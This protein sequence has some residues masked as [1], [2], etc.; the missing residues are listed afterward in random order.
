MSDSIATQ[1]IGHDLSGLTLV[2]PDQ[3][4]EEAFCSSAISPGLQEHV[5]YLA[6][7]VY[8]PPQ[9]MLLTIDLDEHF[10]DEKGITVAP[11]FSLQ[12]A[13]INSSKLDAPEADCFAADRDASF[14]K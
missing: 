7:L 14:G 12:S 6:I 10:V 3:P 9:V 5:D 8:R 4:S 13:G 11:M 1:L 2:A